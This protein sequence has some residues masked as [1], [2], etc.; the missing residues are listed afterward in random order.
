MKSTK[1]PSHF[2]TASLIMRKYIL[3]S[4]NSSDYFF[5]NLKVLSSPANFTVTK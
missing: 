2:E 1:K 5:I 4:L 3:L